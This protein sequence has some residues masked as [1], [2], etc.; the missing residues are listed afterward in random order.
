MSE[1]LYYLL[2]EKDKEIISSGNL[3]KI[4]WLSIKNSFNPF[5]TIQARKY[6]NEEVE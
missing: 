1:D 3:L 2:S 4:S 6:L 5:W